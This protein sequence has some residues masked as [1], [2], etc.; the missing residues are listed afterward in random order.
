MFFFLEVGHSILG[1]HYSNLSFAFHFPSDRIVEVQGTGLLLLTHLFIQETLKRR[2]LALVLR[3]F[4]YHLFPLPSC[5]YSMPLTPLFRPVTC[6]V[7]FFLFPDALFYLRAHNPIKLRITNNPLHS[8]ASGSRLEDKKKRIKVEPASS[9]TSL[10]PSSNLLHPHNFITLHSH[11]NKAMSTPNCK[12]PRPSVP[13]SAAPSRCLRPS[14]R[15]FVL[16][17]QQ[18]DQWTWNGHSWHRCRQLHAQGCSL[19]LLK[20]LKRSPIEG[21]LTNSVLPKRGVPR[22]TASLRP[23]LFSSISPI[24][25]ITSRS[26]RQPRPW[27]CCFSNWRTNTLR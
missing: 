23:I 3:H 20:S 22:R 14:S 6:I 17:Q 25:S 9:S 11:N 16:P 5:H 21:Q 2:L 26:I 7:P 1:T 18:K 8:K 19:S 12:T 24:I 13:T 10:T 4:T 27:S 15:T